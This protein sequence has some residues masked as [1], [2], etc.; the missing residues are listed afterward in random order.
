MSTKREVAIR[1][2][3]LFGGI[4]MHKFYQGDTFVGLLYLIFCWTFIPAL[5]AFADFLILLRMTDQDY[6]RRFG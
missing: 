1:L 4:G 6:V 2:A 3:L 5:L